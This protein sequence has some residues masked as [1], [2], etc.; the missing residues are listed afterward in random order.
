MFIGFLKIIVLIV[1]SLEKKWRI[2]ILEENI[3]LLSEFNIYI[4]EENIL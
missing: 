2:Y 4:L 3:L 1:G